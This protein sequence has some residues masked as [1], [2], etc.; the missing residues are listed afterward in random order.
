MSSIMSSPGGKSLYLKQPFISTYCVLG[1]CL[2]ASH[3]LFHYIRLTVQKESTTVGLF[4]IKETEVSRN[5]VFDW[6]QLLYRTPSVQRLSSSWPCH[7]FQ[8]R[9]PLHLVRSGF[10]WLHKDINT[11]WGRPLP[12][13]QELMDKG[14]CSWL[15]VLTHMPQDSSEGLVWSTQ[16]PVAIN[17]FSYWCFLLSC[18]HP[19]PLF[20]ESH[21]PSKPPIHATSSS[22]A[23][24]LG[25]SS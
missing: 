22:Q 17:A 19:C 2:W 23:L 20:R 1:I 10:L 6:P 18:S 15:T 9:L 25:K 11:S 24:L 3:G 5:E 13:R 7:C 14:F 4:T 8:P 16:S 21:S 12:M